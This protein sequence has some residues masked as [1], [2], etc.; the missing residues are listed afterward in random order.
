[1]EFRE[2]IRQAIDEFNHVEVDEVERALLT[3]RIYMAL[4][5][6]LG[7]TQEKLMEQLEESRLKNRLLE[8][9][10]SVVSQEFLALRES[11]DE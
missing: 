9:R 11:S 1:M 2:T 5:D 10:L 8:S 3:E 4:A 6:Q 7:K